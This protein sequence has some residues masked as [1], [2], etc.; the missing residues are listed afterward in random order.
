MPDPHYSAYD[1]AD[2]IARSVAEGRHRDVI[3]GMW[4]ELGRLQHDFL[5]AQGLQPHHRLI[6]IGCGSLRAGVP[7]ARY[8]DPGHY[9]GID[10][11]PD[12]LTAGLERE[13]APAGLS[14]RL[15]PEN[16]HAT[17]DF[18][19][20]S[21]GVHFDYGIAQSVFTHMPVHRLT[22]CLNA[23]GQFMSPQGRI[24][25]TWF[26][27]PRDHPATGPVRHVPGGIETWADRDPYDNY[28]DTLLAATPS[29][30]T[31]DIIGEWGHPRDQRMALFVR[32]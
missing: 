30:W 3:G 20:S 11:S 31:L 7:L 26:E 16:L 22:D 13:I 6:D 10:I 21:F 32:G 24:Y 2:H 12:L 27:R 25:V 5:V 29:G 8:L 19:L 15:P 1:N 17:G 14:D 28:A 9:Y 23:V 4:D 18:D